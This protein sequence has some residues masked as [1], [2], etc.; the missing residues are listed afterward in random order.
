MIA[1]LQRVSALLAVF[2]AMTATAHASVSPSASEI[3]LGKVTNSILTSW[4]VTLVLV[5]A[6]RI[7]AGTPKLVPSRGQGV[8]ESLFESLRDLLEPIVGKKAFPGAFPLL[9][10]LFTFIL[11]HNWSGLLPGVGTVG[12]GH[13][14]EG[15]FHLTTPFI[16][17]HTADY[18]GTIA[19]A[20]FSFGGWIILCL[21]YAGPK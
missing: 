17:P 20:L 5:L 2:A 15:H 10:S 6:I 12:W 13:D 21:K 8:L 16:R 4:V 7:A 18:N 3:G 19:L 9:A 14:V 11:I 1:R